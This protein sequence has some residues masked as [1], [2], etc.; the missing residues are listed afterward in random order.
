[1]HEPPRQYDTEDNLSAR[2]R[3]WAVS[4]REP[5][6]DLHDWVL[7]L[8]G[9]GRGSDGHRVLE[10]GCGNGS[11]LELVEAV[12]MDR[13]PGML[14]AA[15]QRA[16]GPLV[17]GDGERLPFAAGSCDVVLAPGGTCVAVTNGEGNHRELVDLV[18]G[19]VGHGWRWR[20]PS[21]TVFSMENG[22][23]QLRAGFHTVER[24]N[25]PAGV[26][27]VTDPDTLGD[28]LASVGDMYQ[29]EVA[30]WTPWD[31]VVREC[32]R[33]AAAVIAAD[34][35]FRLAASMGAFVCR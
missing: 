27:L 4:R 20:R 33:R 18:E 1:M 24:V 32:V 26:V 2:Q 10:V 16:I 35:A 25:A 5:T 11:Y 34:G 28:Y 17:C 6:F 22:A 9:L 21:D 8:A 3:L 13:S 30:A 14:A 29:P 31:D 19:V 12:G 7:D 23:A 15:R